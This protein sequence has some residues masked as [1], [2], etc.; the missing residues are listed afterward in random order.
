MNEHERA[1][2]SKLVG[3]C[4]AAFGL[5]AV[6]LVAA[7]VIANVRDKGTTTR[8]AAPKPQP[9]ASVTYLSVAPSITPGP[10]GHLHDAYSTT[11]FNVRV[12]Q[13]MKLVIN[14]TDS[15]AHT[16]TAQQAGVNI[17]I[18]PGSHTYTLLV[19]QPGQFEWHCLMP[20]DPW[21]MQHFG[22]MRGYITA[23]V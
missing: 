18:K 11:N 5:L 7:A 16:I 15:S 23:S 3:V 4:F 17:V 6:C 13:P 1:F 21:A 19:R 8:V 22:Y 14:N 9:V 12:G 10:D 2:N 20:C